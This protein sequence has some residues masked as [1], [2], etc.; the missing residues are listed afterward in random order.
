MTLE[1]SHRFVL[2]SF[3]RFFLSIRVHAEREEQK[4]Q[5]LLNNVL[6]R[7]ANTTRKLLRKKIKERSADTW[8]TRAMKSNAL[9]GFKRVA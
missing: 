9:F 1:H 7:F 4:K 2:E 8:Q 3:A 6:R 5:K